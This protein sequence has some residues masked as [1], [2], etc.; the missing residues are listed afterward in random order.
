MQTK[1]RRKPKGAYHHGQLERALLEAALAT[2]REEGVQALTLRGV[3]SRLSVSRTALYRHFED[4]TALLAR[5]A[6]EGFRLLGEALSGAMAGVPEGGDALQAMGAAYVRFAVNNHSHYQTMFGGFLK[7]WGKYP[8][9]I[10][11]AEAAFSLLLDMI[12][13]EQARGRIISG[14]PIELA[15]VIWSLSHGVAT[16]AVAGQ[17]KRTPASAEDLVL[18][19]C[20]LLENGLRPR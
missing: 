5:V 13:D 2:I 19:G 4:K 14:E 20:R 11:N 1:L 10:E 7:D 6:S 12:R 17:L 16:L 18:L 3:G 15:E 8:D 9:L